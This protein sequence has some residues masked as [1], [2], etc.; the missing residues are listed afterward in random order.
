MQSIQIAHRLF[1]CKTAKKTSYFPQIFIKIYI[2][3]LLTKSRTQTYSTSGNI[4]YESIRCITLRKKFKMNKECVWWHDC[5]KQTC[6][7]LISTMPDIQTFNCQHFVMPQE[8]KTKKRTKHFVKSINHFKQIFSYTEII[9]DCL[10]C[11]EIFCF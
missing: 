7:F 3:I 2:F 10:D 4:H 1:K 8:Q 5:L 6:V 9:S 11:C